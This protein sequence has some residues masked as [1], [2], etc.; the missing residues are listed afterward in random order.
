MK[1]KIILA[2]TL[3]IS[4]LLNCSK[5]KH[6]EKGFSVSPETEILEENK[7]DGIAQ[8]SFKLETRPG[9]VLLTGLSKYRLTTIYM[10]NYDKKSKSY[11]TGYN[12]YYR[13]YTEMGYDNGNRWH[14][15]FMPGLQAIYG[16]NMIN[17]SHYNTE[18]K[19]YNYFFNQPVLIKTLYYPS[20]TKD[21]LNF[22]PVNRDYYLISVYNEDTNKDGFI[23]I[24]DLRHFY[25]FDLDGLNQRA[26][27][28][29]NYSVISSEY[30]P[31]NDFMYVYA[32][33]D[34]NKNGQRDETEDIHIFWIDLKNPN[35]NG[36][37]Y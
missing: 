25:Y 37:Q 17:V 23:N 29:A 18:T 35:H 12:H 1:N 6:V 10:L 26:I 16:Y 3:L 8:D 11:Y 28:P 5:E 27:I 9:N 20:F 7:I 4:S 14:D 31:A 21:T 32:Q 36:R 15:N 2:S 34:E 13:N 30:D 19:K 22:N 24:K 33:L